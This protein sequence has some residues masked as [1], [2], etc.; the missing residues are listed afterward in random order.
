M[1]PGTPT[2]G[3]QDVRVEWS[4]EEQAFTLLAT[5]DSFL[6]FLPTEAA[7]QRIDLS[8]LGVY[9]MPLE[10]A[11]SKRARLKPDSIP[12]LAVLSHLAPWSRR[13]KRSGPVSVCRRTLEDAI[14]LQGQQARH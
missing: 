9:W 11:E 12:V 4:P 2:G 1:Q 6:A 7:R 8:E 5:A 13:V 14:T 10:G 3:P